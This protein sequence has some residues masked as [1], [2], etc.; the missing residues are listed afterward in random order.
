MLEKIEEGQVD[1]EATRAVIAKILDRIRG[2]AFG[3]LPIDGESG[4]IVS[5]TVLRFSSEFNQLLIL[6]GT[7]DDRTCSA[8]FVNLF[9]DVIDQCFEKGSEE[10]RAAHDLRNTVA[11]DVRTSQVEVLLPKIGKMDLMSCVTFLR[12]HPQHFG[13]EVQA[14]VMGRGNGQFV[15]AGYAKGRRDFFVQVLNRDAWARRLS[16]L[17]QQRILDEA[18]G[19]DLEL[20]KLLLEKC[21]RTFDEDMQECF[22]KELKD[23]ED[24]P[25]KVTADDSVH[26]KF[27]DILGS[28]KLSRKILRILNRRGLDIEIF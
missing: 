3:V 13:P 17:Q 15:E 2:D 6:T 20:V 27:V 21:G 4:A 11:H 7:E 24:E 14:L 23:Y 12:K 8:E 25:V 9:G 19:K 5:S 1:V 26:R 18:R 28:A 22:L 10:W 16:P